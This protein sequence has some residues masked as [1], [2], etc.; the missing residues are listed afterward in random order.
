MPPANTKIIGQ[1]FGRLTVI[2]DSGRRSKSGRIFWTCLCDCGNT[3]E[4][5]AP[6]LYSGGST[7]CGC[8]CKEK[9]SSNLIDRKFGKL[10]VL[11][12]TGKSTNDHRKIYLCQCDC[13]N[14]IE[15]NSKL[16]TSGD[17]QSC[18]CNKKSR[19]EQVIEQMLKDN[20]ICYQR[21][22]IDKNCKF[23]TGGYA[24]FDFKIDNYYIEYDGIQHFKQQSSSKSWANEEN[25]TK[26]KI[27]DSEKNEYCL[28]NK[29]PLIRIPYTHLENLCIEDLLLGTSS[30]IIKET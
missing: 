2:G 10:S 9:V 1:K 6:N 16:L 12:D 22:Y 23:S 17:K 11:Q 4:V 29:I 25:F 24:K 3:T 27:R 30:F 7:S 20:N 13:G 28:K 15:V 8:Y 18:G 19:G 14:F 26:I 21:E 5:I